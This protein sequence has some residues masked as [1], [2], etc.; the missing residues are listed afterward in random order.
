MPAHDADHLFFGI[1]C[2]GF[3]L[4][5]TDLISPSKVNDKIK[6]RVMGRDNRHDFDIDRP[7]HSA[8]TFQQSSIS[9]RRHDGEGGHKR[10][11]Q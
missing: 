11:H 1:A 5:K 7:K 2:S 10:Q 4:I 3:N 6:F 8:I 9:N